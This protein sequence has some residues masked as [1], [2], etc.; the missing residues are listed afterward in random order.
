MNRTPLRKRRPT[1]TPRMV[2]EVPQRDLTGWAKIRQ[3]VI[4][5]AVGKCGGCGLPL[6][7]RPEVHHV[8]AVAE[9]GTNDPD[10]LIA[11][12]TDCDC[13]AIETARLKARLAK[14]KRVAAKHGGPYV[15][16]RFQQ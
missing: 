1:A 13:H 9:G 6:G 15:P 4:D 3:F 5:R 16:L 14:A 7:K 2:L 10:N 12:G 11:L 8:L